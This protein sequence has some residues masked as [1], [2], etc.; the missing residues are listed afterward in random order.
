VKRRILALLCGRDERLVAGAMILL[1]LLVAFEGWQLVLKTPLAK[2]RQARETRLALANAIAAAPRVMPDLAALGSE[3][4]EIVGRLHA[5][6]QIPH[7]DDRLTAAVMSELDRSASEHGV[8]LKAVKPGPQ[9]TIGAFEEV[10]YE[11]AAEGK[12]VTLCRWLMQLENAV[13]GR[14]AVHSLALR[15][16][17]DQVWATLRLALYRSANKS[18]RK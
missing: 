4:Q 17:T 1:V 3:V 6:L 8:R 10:S 2:Y 13:G 16:E 18:A 11:V 7:S 9:S 14:A 12:Y 5:E 15:T